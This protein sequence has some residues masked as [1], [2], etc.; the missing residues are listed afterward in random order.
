MSVTPRKRTAHFRWSRTVFEKAILDALNEIPAALANA[1]ENVEFIINDAPAK[2]GSKNFLL[3]LYQGVPL[4]ER[5]L[6]Y[7]NALPDT[8]T[9]YRA[10]IE[11]TAKNRNE[12]VGTIR[13]T[14]IHEVAHYFGMND[15]EIRKRGF[16]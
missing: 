15:R 1:V 11:R 4:N 6:F 5:G 7:Q 16:G 13:D 12:L 14:I 8:I 3:G 2:P 10:N 9:L